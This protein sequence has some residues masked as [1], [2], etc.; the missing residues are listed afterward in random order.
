MMDSPGPL[1][2]QANIVI[3]H[4]GAAQVANVLWDAH[5][6]SGGTLTLRIGAFL[7]WRDGPLHAAEFAFP[8]HAS[9]RQVLAVLR[10]ARPVDHYLTIPEGLTAQQIA[11]VFAEAN[12]AIGDIPPI[13][14]GSVLPETYS[15]ELGTPRPVLLARAQAAMA[16]ALSDAWSNRAP[17][18]PLASPRQAVILASIV[19]RETSRP[20]ERS[21]VAG[22]FLNRLK[23]GMR[24]QA[25]PTVVYAVSGGAGTLDR[26][27]ARADL[28]RDDKF[29]TYRSSGLPPAPIC[30]PGLASIQ[31]V[32]H[33]MQ[34][35][36]LF[37]VADGSGGHAF[38]RTLGEHE[39]N[40]A[41]WR[42][43]RHQ[44]NGG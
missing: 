37:F 36:D 29:N 6:L 27:L 4:G 41:R 21:H 31:A 7:T 33:P 30:A 2:A 25:D 19:E 9:L 22:V 32:L 1:P 35:D 13:E 20:E 11:G 16:R 18:L 12:A 24:L 10:H 39:L 28:E 8:A 14:E 3:P 26:K 5:A 42:A 15:F 44:Q 23:Q 38:A 43:N 40:V 34:S 17:D